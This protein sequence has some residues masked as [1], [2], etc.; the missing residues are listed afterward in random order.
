MAF[1]D[2][3]S[4]GMER[5]VEVIEA[6]L[7]KRLVVAHSNHIVA[8]GHERHVDGCDPAE[9][10]RIN[11]SCQN[12]S[13]NQAMLLKNGREVNPIG[14][15]SGGVMQRG[16]EHVLLQAAGIGFDALQNASMKGVEKIAV[17]QQEADHFRAALKNSAGLRV[18]AESQA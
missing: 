16:E 10:I 17:A 14:R 2:Q 4:R 8:E 1:A 12:E 3:V 15:R 11:R 5:P 9:Q 13:V 18:G 7:I 6:Y